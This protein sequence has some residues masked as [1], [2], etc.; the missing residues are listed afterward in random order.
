MVQSLAGPCSPEL[1]PKRNSLSVRSPTH[2]E[3]CHGKAL[4]AVDIAAW[5]VAVITPDGVARSTRCEL[6]GLPSSISR[7]LPRS[8]MLLFARPAAERRDS[9][10]QSRTSE[11]IL[12]RI[13]LR[14]TLDSTDS[15][16]CLAHRADN[17]IGSII[18][19]N[20]GQNYWLGSY[21]S[22][23]DGLCHRHANSRLSAPAPA[24]PDCSYL[25]S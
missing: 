16:R 2:V 22:K 4:N 9:K 14:S 15:I 1:K 13:W 19:R 23:F 3:P 12:G 8:P 11:L 7:Q 5:Q 18:D 20:F 21:V 17:A 6:F 10:R 25:Q 24:P